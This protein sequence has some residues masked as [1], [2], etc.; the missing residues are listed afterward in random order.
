MS[1]KT[2]I[3]FLFFIFLFSGCNR[4]KKYNGNYIPLDLYDAIDFLD[5]RL[6]QITKENLKKENENERAYKSKS[7][8]FDQLLSRWEI[9]HDN[10]ILT[11]Y[12]EK[13]AINDPYQILDIIH[14]SLIRK[15]SGQEIRLANQIDSI[16]QNRMRY[17]KRINELT[18]DDTPDIIRAY[19]KIQKGDTLVI[20]LGDHNRELNKSTHVI[21]REDVLKNNF[22]ELGQCVGIVL[23]KSIV[24][25]SRHEKCYPDRYKVYHRLSLKVISLR[26]INSF[27]YDRGRFIRFEHGFIPCKDENIV[28][29]N[30]G[31]GNKFSFY[32]EDS[33]TNI[34]K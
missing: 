32:L 5:C 4:C 21:R 3:L 16:G 18:R 10:S 13:L 9:G 6:D 24:N 1:A 31:V 8:Y 29:K 34:F 14:T 33:G 27:F 26:G 11:K 7:Y 23:S 30:V 28:L 12:F 22:C 25:K 15:L 19:L 17:I 2:L 20:T